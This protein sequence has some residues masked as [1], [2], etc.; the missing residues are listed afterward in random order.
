[1]PAPLAVADNFRPQTRTTAQLEIAERLDRFESKAAALRT[2]TDHYAASAWNNQLQPQ[3]HAY[4]LNA[5]R[6]QVNDLGRELSKLEE[7][8]PQGTEL[9]Q[10]AIREARPELQAVADHVQSAIA[11]L[12]EDKRNRGTPAFQEKVKGMNESAD[13]LYSKVDAL[14]DYEK[15]GIRA[16]TINDPAD[17]EA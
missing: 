3:S 12:N 15:A 11:M 9:Q 4:E 14:T 10:A 2:Q 5:A 17:P 7:L 6:V 8:S 13:S 16:G 1:M